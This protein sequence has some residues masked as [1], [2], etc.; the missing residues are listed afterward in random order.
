MRSDLQEAPASASA[1]VGNAL[2]DTAAVAKA[3][4]AAAAPA[5]VA[6]AAAAA[7]PQKPEISSA[8]PPSKQRNLQAE[9]EQVSAAFQRLATRDDSMTAAAIPLLLENC[10]LLRKLEA[11]T[12]HDTAAG[13][14][15]PASQAEPLAELN[16][17]DGYSLKRREA[18]CFGGN[19]ATKR[20]K[21]QQQSPS[22]QQL[23]MADVEPFTKPAARKAAVKGR[24]LISRLPGYQPKGKEN[25][26]GGAA[27]K[28]VTLA[29]QPAAAGQS[30]VLA[31][32]LLA[33]CLVVCGTC[34]AGKPA[35]VMPLPHSSQTGDAAAAAPASQ[36][37][38]APVHAALPAMLPVPSAV[39]QPLASLPLSAWPAAGWPGG[40]AAG[41]QPP[42]L[43]PA[44]MQ[45]MAALLSQQQLQQVPNS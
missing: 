26:D 34:S 17:Q 12:A 9:F 3:A 41:L 23:P 37:V 25:A 5:A 40:A 35:A 19:A 7:A 16:P 33:D 32:M 28:A 38:P 29:K 43:T 27:A 24:P 20:R 4:P 42:A 6:P 18:A 11:R 14:L 30:R 10:K 1:A 44:M 22:A 31:A 36:L 8:N 45:F 13:V 15:H 2:P 21:Q 39:S